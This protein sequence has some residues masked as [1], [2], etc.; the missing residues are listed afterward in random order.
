M[1]EGKLVLTVEN[2]NWEG[3]FYGKPQG[4]FQRFAKLG[5]TTDL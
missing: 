3:E 4:F 2:I 1:I 5:K